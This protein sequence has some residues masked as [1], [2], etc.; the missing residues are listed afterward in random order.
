MSDHVAFPARRLSS[1]SPHPSPISNGHAAA[2]A[3]AGAHSPPP[4]S[5]P[6]SPPALSILHRGR[7]R[8]HSASS[9]NVAGETSSAQ[10]ALERRD[11]TNAQPQHSPMLL[12]RDLTHSELQ[13]ATL[14][15]EAIPA[16]R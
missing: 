16:F 8:H 3:A 2:A 14:N 9:S 4:S 11:S 7:P 5:S 10:P 1:R 6:S 12:I 15:G 13:D